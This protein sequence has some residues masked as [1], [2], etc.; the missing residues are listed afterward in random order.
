MRFGGAAVPGC[1]RKEK[2]RQIEKQTQA[3]IGHSTRMH[4]G[5]NLE[6][7]DQAQ[8][9]AP[10]KNRDGPWTE[11]AREMCGEMPVVFACWGRVA[12]MR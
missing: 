9:G 10:G 8:V 4:R 2:K 6:K 3:N 11:Q 7:K 1:E 12:V 5:G